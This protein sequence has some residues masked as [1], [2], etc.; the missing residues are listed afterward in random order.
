MSSKISPGGDLFLNGAKNYL[1]ALS[2]IA[3]FRSE[4][5]EMCTEI[6]KHRAPELAAQMGLDAE[7]CE[8][9]E[10]SSPDERWAEVGI[11]RPAQQNCFFYLY[12]S[13]G[14]DERVDDMIAGAVSL[15][16]YHKRLRDEIYEQLQK[17]PQHRVKKFDTYSLMLT[18]H[19]KDPT[20]ARDVLDALVS[21]WIGSCK[22]IGGLKLGKRKAM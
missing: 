9:F 5:Q 22:S 21:E 6:Y 13:W 2:A 10:E 11:S 18:E 7:D 20:C 17:G 12:L 4:V 19:I 1:D 15:D 8:P 16:L 3:A 14:E